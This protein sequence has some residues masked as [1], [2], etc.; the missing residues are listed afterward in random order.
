M[1]TPINVPLKAVSNITLLDMYYDYRKE[2][3]RY[4]YMLDSA[5]KSHDKRSE[6]FYFTKV[7][8]TSEQYFM[9]RNEVLS[10]MM[11]MEID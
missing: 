6:E 4:T 5:K 10:R 1:V 7:T 2:L 3:N 11:G 8:E 9:I